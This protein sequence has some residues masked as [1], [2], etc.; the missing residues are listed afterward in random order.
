MSRKAPYPNRSPFSF[1]AN[2]SNAFHPAA[3]GNAR[4]QLQ[5]QVGEK[6]VLW[7]AAFT[8]CVDLVETCKISKLDVDPISE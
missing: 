4:G 1:L 3:I 6:G 8:G 2:T 5:V 7:V